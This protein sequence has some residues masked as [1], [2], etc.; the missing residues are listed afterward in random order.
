MKLK[1]VNFLLVAVGC[2]VKFRVRAYINRLF[3]SENGVYD[4]GG[5]SGATIE[6]GG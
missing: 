3:V 2:F 6:G 1:R 4:G 5:G